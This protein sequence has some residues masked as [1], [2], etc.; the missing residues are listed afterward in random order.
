MILCYN[1]YGH[2]KASV[3]FAPMT[4][5]I[6]RS[7]GMT[8]SSARTRSFLSESHPASASRF[9]F[10]EMTDNKLLELERGR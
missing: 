10:R 1:N 6:A 4:N 3:L 2:Q 5:P 8:L 7:S 9:L